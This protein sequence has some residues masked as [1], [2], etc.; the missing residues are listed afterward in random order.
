MCREKG[1]NVIHKEKKRILK[2]GTRKNSG[3]LWEINFFFFFFLKSHVKLHNLEG[4]VEKIFQ[5]M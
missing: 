5:I 1:E 3:K 2:K 4:K